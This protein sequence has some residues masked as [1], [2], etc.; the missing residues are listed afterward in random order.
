MVEP[1]PEPNPQLVDLTG[2]NVIDEVYLCL[3]QQGSKGGQADCWIAKN[4]FE[5]HFAVKVYHHES[6]DVAKRDLITEIEQYRA[7]GE[8]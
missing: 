6:I 2:P 4:N 1:N 8:H 7:L 5:E 3:L